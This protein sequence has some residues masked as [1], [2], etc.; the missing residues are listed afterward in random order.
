M[1]ET[2]YHIQKVHAYR[3]FYPIYASTAF[4]QVFLKQLEEELH[5]ADVKTKDPVSFKTNG[6]F[7]IGVYVG[8][9]KAMDL[10]NRI[11]KEGETSKE[12][13]VKHGINI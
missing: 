9:K 2:A 13:C 4:N 1:D 8:L 11:V 6:E 3:D 12:Y 5:Y 10:I 7:N